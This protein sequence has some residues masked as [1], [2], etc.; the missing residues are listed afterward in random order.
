MLVYGMMKCS[1]MRSC[2]KS[3]AQ[4]GADDGDFGDAADDDGVV[5]GDN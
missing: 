3:A 4:G 5:S 1:K 2:P